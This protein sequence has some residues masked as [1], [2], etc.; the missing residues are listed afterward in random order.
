MQES[1][2]EINSESPDHSAPRPEAQARPS[3]HVP[4]PSD[5]AGAGD[6]DADP[7]PDDD[8]SLQAAVDEAIAQ[9]TDAVAP[10]EAAERTEEAPEPAAT[11]V[12][13]ASEASD[14]IEHLD[15]H[16]AQQGA[17]LAEEE[18][19]SE[20]IRDRAGSAPAPDEQPPPIVEKGEKP[21]EPTEPGARKK[22][23]VKVSIRKRDTSGSATEDR[24]SDGDAD[25]AAGADPDASGG[26]SELAVASAGSRGG[27]ERVLMAINAPLRY[28]PPQ[29][30]DYIGWFGLL[31]AFNAV[32]VWI[33][34]ALLRA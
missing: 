7:E 31:T 3:D 33:F 16:L 12:A 9:A 14:S 20:A 11:A 13:E 29:V 18:P 24:A 8:G 15:E 6:S 17:S 25:A 2:D 28:V 19:E 22:P 10:V 30:R 32:C 4:D 23:K 5:F 27:V 34:W 1:I 21:A 26:S